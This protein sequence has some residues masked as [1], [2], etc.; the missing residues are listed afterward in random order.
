MQNAEG[1]TKKLAQET[2]QAVGSAAQDGRDA[3]GAAVRDTGQSVASAAHK[4]KTPA[5]IGAATL[6][7]VGGGIA[8]GSKAKLRKRKRVLGVRVLHR[9]AVGDAAKRVGKAVDSVSSTGQQ[10]GQWSD[11]VQYL[12]QRLAGKSQGGDKQTA[13]GPALAVARRILCGTPERSP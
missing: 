5:L 13:G 11:D 1:P 6:A 2:E 9:T 7:T 8:L 4:A 12:R 3:V 10:I